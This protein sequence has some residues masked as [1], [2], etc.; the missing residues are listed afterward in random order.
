MFLDYVAFG[1]RRDEGCQYRF[2]WDF[3]LS[4]LKLILIMALVVGDW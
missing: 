4:V 1:V 3:I 2:G